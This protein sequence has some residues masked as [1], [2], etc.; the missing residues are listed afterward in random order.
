[1][2]APYIRSS[3]I[4]SYRVCAQK[5]FINY[6][7]GISEKSKFST[8]AGTATHKA[9]ELLAQKKKAIQDSKDFLEN[10]IFEAP[11]KTHDITQE[12][13]FELGWNF[14]KKT[15]GGHKEWDDID[16]K[17]KYRHM[18]YNLLDGDYNPLKLDVIQP[19]Q[20]F[21]FEIEEDWA[22][23]SYEIH[24]E[25]FA[26]FLR[27]KG[28]MDLIFQN[29]GYL[30]GMDYKTGKTRVDWAT[31]KIKNIEDL[32][33]DKQLLLYSYAISKIF[34]IKEFSIIMYYL[35][36][37]GPYEVYYDEK[38]YKKAY[39][40]IKEY[41]LKISKDMTPSLAKDS[42]KFFDRNKCKWC[43]YS[44]YNEE[45]SR[46]K[47]ICQF[48]HEETMQLGMAKVIEKYGKPEKIFHY[49]SGGGK[50]ISEKS[51]E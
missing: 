2:L 48:F 20:Y 39:T 35:Q 28:T 15:I 6:N 44:K 47:T 43:S 21:D 14:C 5:S 29:N 37:G 19:E 42:D 51:V 8:D 13:A 17:E 9:L 23:Y 41:F 50:G 3:Y 38:T 45:F 49:G 1:M 16:S 4:G 46:K 32:K 31:G 34:G 25:K 36:A 40:M 30:S 26:G 10:E 7:L 12:S 33:E 22:R 27:I 11:Y 24:G 18:Y